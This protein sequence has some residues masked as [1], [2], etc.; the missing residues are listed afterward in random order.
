[1]C[2]LETD[3][4]IVLAAVLILFIFMLYF[5]MHSITGKVVDPDSEDQDDF[6]LSLDDSEEV[7]VQRRVGNLDFENEQHEEQCNFDDV[8]KNKIKCKFNINVNEQNDFQFKVLSSNPMWTIQYVK[9]KE[10]IFG[11]IPRELR[12]EDCNNANCERQSGLLD[13]GTYTVEI[14]AIKTE[15]IVPPQQPPQQTQPQAP[16]NPPP[17]QQVNQQTYSLSVSKAGAGTGTVTGSGINCG[18]SCNANFNDGAQ[19]VLSAVSDSG[20]F[21]GKM[22]RSRLIQS[23]R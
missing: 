6:E 12:H 1:M 2:K 13:P 15:N 22:G 14:L 10:N 8:T 21:F 17:Q 18:S 3:T 23:W 4:K 5:N 11:F 20:S 19:I 9:I 7:E 16:V